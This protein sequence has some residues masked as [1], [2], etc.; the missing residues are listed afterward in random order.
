[1]RQTV[2]KSLW[3]KAIEYSLTHQETSIKRV[4]AELKRIWMETP[5]DKKKILV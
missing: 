5:R 1:M 4:Y 2:E 3:K